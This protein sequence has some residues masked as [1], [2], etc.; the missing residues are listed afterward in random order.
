MSSGYRDGRGAVYKLT[1][2]TPTKI[3]QNDDLKTK[4]NSGVAY[5]GHIYGVSEKKGM[6][7]CLDQKTGA[8]KWQERKGGQFGTLM[9]AGGKLIVLS[10]SGEL[11]IAEAQPSGYK[12]LASAKVLN[13]RCWVA[14]VLANGHIY[15][16]TNKGQMV[17]VKL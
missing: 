13:G 9:I 15:A 7:M 11:V 6:L 4:M 8:V 16:K 5:E 12:Q 17:C 10:D 2:G 3:W 14:P 1:G